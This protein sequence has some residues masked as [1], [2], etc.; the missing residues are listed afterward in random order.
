MAEAKWYVSCFE[1]GERGHEL[2]NI[3]ASALGAGKGK[4]THFSQ[5]TVLMP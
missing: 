2:R 1:D 3:R 5:D 4:G